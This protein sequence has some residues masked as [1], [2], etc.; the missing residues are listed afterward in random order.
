MAWVD[1]LPRP[2]NSLLIRKSPA[3]PDET[4]DLWIERYAE[5][6]GCDPRPGAVAAAIENLKNERDSVVRSI[7]QH[8][9]SAQDALIL[10]MRRTAV[11]CGPHPSCFVSHWFKT[12]EE[13][14]AK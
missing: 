7:P 8:R 13:R 4:T 1:G 12:R 2:L 10:Q 9:E 14:A 6:L 3:M 11:N 5:L